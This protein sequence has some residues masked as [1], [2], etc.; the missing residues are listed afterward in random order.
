VHDGHK[1]TEPAFLQVGGGKAKD[2]FFPGFTGKRG[3][4][5]AFPGRFFSTASRIRGKLE[6]AEVPMT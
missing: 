1:A 6:R 2:R 5:G 3:Q 4:R